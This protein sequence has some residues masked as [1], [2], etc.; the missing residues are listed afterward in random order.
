MEMG[1]GIRLY[2][3]NNRYITHTKTLNQEGLGVMTLFM[4]TWAITSLSLWAASYVFD[5][6]QFNDSG[7]LIISA[8]VL[9]F[10]N[11]L[12]RPLVI[13]FTLPLT[14][15]TMGLFLLV[16]NALVLMLVAKLVS[17]FSLAG[18]WTAFFASIFIS[19]LNVFISS[20]FT[21]N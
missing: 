15:L 9:G 18:F 16:I 13:V 10:A 14:V 21:S 20:F 2:F 7:A 11:A 6:L 8:L 4:L 5:G 3:V 12:V 19:L 17:G 1:F